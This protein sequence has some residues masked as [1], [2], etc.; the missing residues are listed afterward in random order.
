LEIVCHEIRD[1]CDLNLGFERLDIAA[2]NCYPIVWGWGVHTLY[3]LFMI[4]TWIL[5]TIWG[6]FC[7]H[8]FDALFP[9]IWY[10]NAMWLDLDSGVLHVQ[11]V[12]ESATLA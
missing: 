1:I 3:M 10:W 12:R 11:T 8:K 9:I 7:V 4:L 5:G 6:L 2:W